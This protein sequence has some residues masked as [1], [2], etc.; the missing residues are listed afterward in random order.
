MKRP[1]AVTIL[2]GLF[3]VAGMVGLVYHLRERPL[4]PRIVLISLIRVLAIVGGIFVLRGRSWA[5]WLLVVWLGFHV[6]VS[7]FHSLSEALAHAALLLLVGYFLFWP[8]A[9]RYFQSS[10]PAAGD[11]GPR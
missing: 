6:V 9:G 2:G 10:P 3:I 4:E 11:S 5:R 7:A 8:P 1:T